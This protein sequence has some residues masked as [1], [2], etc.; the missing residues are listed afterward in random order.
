M[1]EC[2]KPEPRNNE[3]TMKEKLSGDIV[4]RRLSW[5]AGTAP[6]DTPAQH[7][8]CMQCQTTLKSILLLIGSQWSSSRMAADRLLNLEMF[9]TSRAAEFNTDWSRS[10]KQNRRKRTAAG[11]AWARAG[12]LRREM[13]GWENRSR[14]REMGWGGGGVEGRTWTNQAK[15]GTMQ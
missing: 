8:P 7:Q 3:V 11:I 10:R 6:S 12:G 13:G 1:A 5:L 9:R 14:R 15:R 2:L 4:D